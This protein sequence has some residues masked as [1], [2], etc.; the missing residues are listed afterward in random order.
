MYIGLIW[1]AWH[2][3]YLFLFV[4]TTEHMVTFIPRIVLGV[5]MLSIVYGEIRLMTNSVWPA[6]LMHT[7]GNA[8]IDTLILKKY[9]VIQDDYAYLVM[10]SPDG[11][12]SIVITGLIGLW[13]YKIR[14]SKLHS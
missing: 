5:V 3:P 12:I 6:V 11:I 9:V 1:A 7:I 13:L 10:P 8:F 2:F 14:V 4:D